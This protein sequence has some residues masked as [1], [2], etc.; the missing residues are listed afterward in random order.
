MYG[1]YGYG[2]AS[3]LAELLEKERAELRASIADLGREMANIRS[4]RQEKESRLAHVEALL[5]INGAAPAAVPARRSARVKTPTPVLLDMAAA[6]LRERE[7]EPMHYRELAAQL[8]ERGA[9]IGG[10]DAAAGLVSRMS[11]DA[12][13]RFLRP[14][15]KGFYALREDYPEVKK[16]VGEKRRRR[17]SRKEKR[18]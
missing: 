16:S 4:E 10:K 13:K 6:L 2:S 9:V 12:Q 3:P 7:K 17:V 15:S 1:F 18:G 5:G 11:K 14:T 8:Q